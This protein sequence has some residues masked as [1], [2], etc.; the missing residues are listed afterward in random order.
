LVVSLTLVM[1]FCKT[2]HHAR[3]IEVLDFGHRWV[4]PSV[5]IYEAIHAEWPIM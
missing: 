3:L 4:W 5:G 1:W 2:L